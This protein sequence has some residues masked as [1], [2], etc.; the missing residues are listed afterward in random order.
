MPTPPQVHQG[1]TSKYK[2][3]ELRTLQFQATAVSLLMALPA[4]DPNVKVL[5]M[6]LMEALAVVREQ[7][8]AALPVLFTVESLFKFKVV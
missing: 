4:V 2:V 3:M 5:F 6:Q 1:S 7:V 8:P